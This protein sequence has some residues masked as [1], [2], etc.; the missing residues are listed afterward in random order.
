MKNL[1]SNKSVVLPNSQAH[2]NCVSVSHCVLCLILFLLFFFW[3]DCVWFVWSWCVPH[4]WQKTVEVVGWSVANRQWKWW[5]GHW[6]MTVKVVGWELA[7]ICAAFSHLFVNL[8]NTRVRHPV[9]YKHTE[10][11]GC[12]NPKQR[13]LCKQKHPMPHPLPPSPFLTMGRPAT[14]EPAHGWEK[15]KGEG[16][17][18]LFLL[19]THNG[20]PLWGLGDSKNLC[21]IQSSFLSIW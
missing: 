7:R 10:H 18:A 1:I 16:D 6:Q 8:I 20:Q 9:D 4:H 13:V 19:P 11:W 2:M 17:G 14:Q 3:F 21:S 5:G 12:G 15:G